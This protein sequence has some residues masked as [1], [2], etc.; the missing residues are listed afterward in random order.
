MTKAVAGDIVSVAGFQETTVT[1]TLN[2]IGNSHVIPV[3]YIIYQQSLF[4]NLSSH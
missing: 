1:H 3:S 2:L 4:S